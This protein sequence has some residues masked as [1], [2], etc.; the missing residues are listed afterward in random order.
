MMTPQRI[1][2]IVGFA[3]ELEEAERRLYPSPSQQLDQEMCE[4]ISTLV[5]MI[6]ELGSESRSA[7]DEI[8]FLKGRIAFLEQLMNSAVDTVV[9]VKTLPVQ[10]YDHG[11]MAPGDKYV[12]WSTVREA[13]GNDDPEAKP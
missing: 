2:E 11:H 9:R 7:L 1:A 10:V 4:R 12:E 13:L 6:D 5:G 3:H 8:G